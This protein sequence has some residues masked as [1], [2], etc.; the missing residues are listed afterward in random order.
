MSRRSQSLRKK[1]SR[2][3]RFEMFEKRRCM[4]SD[5]WANDGGDVGHDGYVNTEFNA[6][7]LRQVWSIQ[8]PL[9]T[10]DSY[11][12]PV[13]MDD[14]FIYQTIAL[15]GSTAGGYKT[16]RVVAM[17]QTNGEEIWSTEVQS[18]DYSVTAPT[19]DNGVIYVNSAGHSQGLILNPS[20]PRKPRIYGLSA[21]TGQILFSIPYAKQWGSRDRPDIKGNQL[22]IEAGYYGGVGSYNTTNL[23]NQ[24][25]SG[26]GLTQGGNL[27]VGSNFVYGFRNYAFSLSSGA[28]TYI[29][30]PSNATLGQSIVSQSGRVINATS[31]G[32]AAL[33]GTNNSLLWSTALWASNIPSPFTTVSAGNGIV[34]LNVGALVYFL[35]E[36]NGTLIST[37]TNDA[38]FVNY[39][40][41]LTN[42][43]AFV[44][45][46]SDTTSKIQAVN[47]QTMAVDW[48]FQSGYI[49]LSMGL[50]GDR[51][52][53]TTRDSIR[54]FDVI[55]NSPPVTE[56]NTVFGDEDASLTGTVLA[57]DENGDQLTYQVV[58]AP[59]HGELSLNSSTGEWTYV[60][61]A[62]Y[63]GDD[64]FVFFAN[65]GQLDSNLATVT[66][67][68]APVN[69]PPVVS[70]Q[71]PSSGLE[72]TA[73]NLVGS[74]SDLE[75][76]NELLSFQWG[77]TKDGLA[78]RSGSTKDYS[79]TPD[80]N[81]VY[82]VTLTVTDEAGASASSS[83]TILVDNVAPTVTL[84]NVPVSSPEGSTITLNAIASDPAGF[85]DPLTYSWKVIKNQLD[86]VFGVGPT[87]VLTPDDNGT[88]EVLLTVEDGDQG[89]TVV[90]RV[91]NV[92]NVAPS[93]AIIGTPT[94]V[95]E[96]TQVS[97]LGVASDPAG[98]N[99]QLELT[100]YIFKRGA[101]Y[102]TGSGNSIS[103]TPDDDGIY[104]VNFSAYDFDGATTF[105][106]EFFEVTNV[107]PTASILGAPSTAPEGTTIT[108]SSQVSDPAGDQ[109]LLVQ[110]WVVTK[111]GVNY[112]TGN[113]SSLQFTATDNGVY[114]VDLTVSDDEGGIVTVSKSIQVSNVAPTLSLTGPS[115]GEV[116]MSLTFL[117]TAT[118][119]AGV[120][121]PLQYSWLVTLN[122]T[123]IGTAASGVSY[124]FVPTLP[125]TYLVSLTV[126]DG[127]GGITT[128]THQVV[129]TAGSVKLDGNQ[130]VILGTS[131]ND[132]IEV[133][134][135]SGQF[136]VYASFLPGSGTLSF[137]SSLV[138]SITVQSRAGNDVIVIAA[139]VNR[140]TLL[141]GEDGN[142]TIRGGAGPDVILGGNGVDSLWGNDGKDVLDGE[143]GND[144]LYGGN[145]A[146]ILL[147]GDGDDLLY[148]G[149]GNDV[150]I[151]G[152]G[153]DSLFGNEG[154]DLLIGSRTTFDSNRSALLAIL[155]EWDSGRSYSQRIS[156]LQGTGS[157]TRANGNNFLIKNQTVINDTA[158][159]TLRGEDGRDWFFTFPL[160][161]IADK[162]SNETVT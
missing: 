145:Q 51:L 87:L 97:L 30:N 21:A 83:Q 92:E 53:V 149:F 4:A 54:L 50:V 81:G 89:Q 74:A 39:E 71:S 133:K 91:I 35:N 25:S 101:L 152:L 102:T 162:K 66:L 151:G 8:T 62:N 1:T 64:Q 57:S 63:F 113:S 130:L 158:R 127:D 77:I 16:F 55:P 120:N 156:N 122:G 7:E 121:D 110:S 105:A 86:F 18:Y 10:S 155:A 41:I 42:S 13:A 139:S 37:W 112:T 82:V 124:G 36:T 80:D 95:S 52:F 159:D 56:S 160:D 69:D 106:T 47:L 128:R 78:Y 146:D 72:G 134:L 148:G 137:N 48:E 75:T 117:S 119:P 109:D 126:D 67:R 161:V 49:G 28:L 26:S 33:D 90:S 116:G 132:Q 44:Y 98:V 111:D 138:N 76:S 34:A 93:V 12:L 70:I 46:N 123:T 61:S 84:D 22:I 40:T 14:Q 157:G 68:I 20:D 140:P 135:T 73:I 2:L 94:S 147:G 5:F 131:N 107:A 17:S 141:N 31:R 59:V 65:D 96:G 27:A 6:R 45:S 153:V 129:V 143:G 79:F 100:W 60:P 24:W 43:H 142:D 115:V 88:Y 99:D 32:V 150:L 104:Q 23:L 11:R 136:V 103:F 125:G 144:S 118:D 85:N 108:L 29:P 3:L 154:D 38:G 15:P 58:T 19:I 9:N 114:S